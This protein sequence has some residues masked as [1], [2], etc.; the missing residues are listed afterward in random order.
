MELSLAYIVHLVLIIL[1]VCSFLSYKKHG[2]KSSTQKVEERL[3]YQGLISSIP[4]LLMITF[5][6]LIRESSM[7]LLG[8]YWCTSH[9]PLVFLWFN[10]ELRKDYLKTFGLKGIVEKMKKIKRGPNAIYSVDTQTVARTAFDTQTAVKTAFDT[11][12]AA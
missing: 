3:L 7:S 2:V 5:H 12:I 9:R 10:K 4:C 1:Y 11:Q 8:S 6:H